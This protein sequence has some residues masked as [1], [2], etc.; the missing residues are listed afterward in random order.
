MNLPKIHSITKKIFVALL[1]AFLLIFLLFHA[2][3]NLCVLRNDDGA[4]YSAFCHFMG[5][6]YVVKVFE[7][8]L[9]LALLAHI[10]ITIWLWIT[11]KAARPV[12]YH[13][14]SRTKTHTGSKLQVWTG[15]LIL[16]F[17]VVHFCDFYFAKIGLVEGKYMLQ[18]KD[19]VE[20]LQNMDEEK[21]NE[22]SASFQLAQQSAQYGIA[23]DTIVTMSLQGIEEQMSSLDQ[24]DSNYAQT[25]EQLQM[26]HE[27]IASMQQSAAFAQILVPFIQAQGNPDIKLPVNAEQIDALY[28]I[29]PDIDVE[30][31]FYNM[32]RAK[33][34]FWPMS[35]LYLAFFVI[36]WFHMRHAFAALFQTLGLNN[37]K[38]NK[39]IEV[40]AVAYAWIVCLAFAAVPIV[41]LLTL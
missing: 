28:A 32:V 11:N 29:F 10:V 19:L 30:P 33:F 20:Q 41:I 1:G 37:Y 24:S 34:A 18:G 8:V 36:L 21:Q 23:P 14:P 35:I 3:A 27:Q 2:C 13:Q 26:Q 7:V 17:L 12:G 31:D 25:M 40:C 5:T 6:N 4:W 9:L 15:I 38:Y 16:A 39:A 22:L